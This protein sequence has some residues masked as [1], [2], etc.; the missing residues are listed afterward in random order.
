MEQMNMGSP[1]LHHCFTIASPL[2]QHCL[3]TGST[4]PQGLKKE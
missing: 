2:P 4:L 3:N 1:L